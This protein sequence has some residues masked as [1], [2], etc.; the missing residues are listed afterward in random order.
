MILKHISPKSSTN[1]IHIEYILTKEN[2]P[3]KSPIHGYFG[4]YVLFSVL[5]RVPRPLHT[6]PLPSL[7][8]HGPLFVNT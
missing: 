8:L 6:R 4:H 3:S 2:H 7:L 5:M 1:D